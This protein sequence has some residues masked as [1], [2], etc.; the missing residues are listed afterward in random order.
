M[1]IWSRILDA[2]AAI[3]AGE[4]FST[5]LEK[6]TTPPEKSVAFT[7]AVIG[8]GAKMAKADGEVTVNEVRAF[9]QVFHIRK[10][11]EVRAAQVFNL[12]RQ[13][14]AGYQ[15]YATQ[16]ARMFRADHAVLSDILEGLFHIAVADGEYHFQEDDYIHHVAQIFGL[17]HSC[18]RSLKARFA[19]DAT[20]DA[21][22]I[23]EVT[24]DTPLH[25]IR[26]K[27]REKVRQTHPDQMIARGL[28]EEAIAMATKRTADLNKAW[29]EINQKHVIRS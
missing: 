24:P 26:Q 14:T 16:I 11:D 8:L 15:T 12:A 13:D 20:P 6:L 29:E 17:E 7:I 28:P 27:W 23:L 10:E 5:V 25:V 4:S 18:Y 19:P 3:K 9:R 21:Y 2:L 22:D 1:S